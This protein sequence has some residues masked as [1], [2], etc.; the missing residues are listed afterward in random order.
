MTSRDPWDPTLDPPGLPKIL[1]EPPVR[2]K[3]LVLAPH[4]DDET[5]GMGG[6]MAMHHELGDPV[7]VLFLT[8]GQT[9]N[10]DGRYGHEEYIRLRQEESRAACKILGVRDLIFWEYPDNHQVTENDMSVLVPRLVEVLKQGDY[11]V[12]YTS[13]RGEMHTDHHVAAVTAVRAIK[14][15][16]KSVELVG[17]EIWGPIEAAEFV[18]NIDRVLPKKLEAAACY[19]SQLALSDFIRLF[20]CLN[21]YRA[22]F[23][24]K[25]GEYGEAFL[26]MRSG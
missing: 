12:V 17:Y 21:G 13:H 4:A 1:D 14:E 3:V 20:K 2:G 22:V 7:D 19:K 15:W 24:E 8:N 18:V 23:M 25:R 9:G 5:I 26:R 10:A 6:T 16:G 11:D